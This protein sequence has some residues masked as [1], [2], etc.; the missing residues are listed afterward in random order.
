MAMPDNL[1]DAKG[2]RVADERARQVLDVSAAALMTRAARAAFD[3]LLQRYPHIKAVSVWCGKGNNGGDA[4][5][6]AA[7]AQDLGLAVQLVRVAPLEELSGDAL[8]A[9][10]RALKAGILPVDYGSDL[11]VRGDVIVDGLLGT[12][13]HGTPCAAYT[14]AIAAINASAAPVLSI[15][16]PSG[17]DV[18]SGDTP[19]VAVQAEVTVTFITSKVGLATGAGLHMAGD[20]VFASLGVPDEIYPPTKFSRLAWLPDSLATLNQ[21]AYKHEH[22]HALVIGGATGMAGA[23]VLASRAALRAG[24]GLASVVTMP[25]H[26]A[27]V[28]GATPEAMVVTDA[29]LEQK[30]SDANVLV[31]GPGLG[32]VGWGVELYRRAEA[33]GLPTVLDADGLYHLAEAQQWLG[34]RLFITPHS[35]EAA[36]L[37]QISPAVIEADRLGSAQML[38]ERFNA[39]VALKGP[40]TVV[41]SALGDEVSICQ[42]GNPGMASAGMGDVLAGLLG[43]LLAGPFRRGQVEL[44]D[45]FAQGVALHSAAADHAAQSVGQRSLLASDVVD[46]LPAMFRGEVK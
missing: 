3:V 24:T 42:H 17:V 29:Q 16:V 28:I 10:Q 39:D 46:A 8:A 7:M 27:I 30:F 43:G 35:G 18:S 4:F 37:L 1:Y 13:V 32:R 44:S 23:I 31:V 9:H 15:D 41:A 45:L 2:S 38:A 26:A 21:R 11:I 14:D 22:G 33:S 34:G 12:G 19:G 20:V 25:A 40:G 36:R 6:L 5:L